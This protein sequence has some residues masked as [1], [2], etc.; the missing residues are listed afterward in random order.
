[1]KLEL[2]KLFALKKQ[3]LKLESITTDKGTLVADDDIEVG[4]AVFMDGENG[5]MPAEDGD[6][7]YD[8][9]T[10]TVAGG[11]VTAITENEP[12]PIVEE[13]IV[14]EE[15]MV[16][17]PIVVEEPICEPIIDEEKEALK[18]KV[19]ELEAKMAELEA[20]L[21]ESMAKPADEEMPTEEMAKKK[22]KCE[23]ELDFVAMMQKARELK[24][25]K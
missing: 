24:N 11:I 23:K 17:E 18:A 12:Q 20:K 6:Y 14:V 4:V 9:K 21:A 5:L 25:S 16:E 22:R 15:P 19:A 2:S 10:I 7:V 13:P 3:L 8:T 1:M